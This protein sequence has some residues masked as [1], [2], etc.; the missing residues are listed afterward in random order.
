[1]GEADFY[2][3][4]KSAIIAKKERLESVKGELAAAYTRWEELEQLKSQE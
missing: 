1:M 4:E 3:N 2:K